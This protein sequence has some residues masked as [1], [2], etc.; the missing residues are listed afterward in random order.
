M[1]GKWRSGA[2]ATARR[3][4][5]KILEEEVFILCPAYREALLWINW[6]CQVRLRDV[7]ILDC[8]SGDRGAHSL[9]NFCEAHRLDCEGATWQVARVEEELRRELQ[10]RCADVLADTVNAGIS[11]SAAMQAAFQISTPAEL[12][13]SLPEYISCGTRVRVQ[14]SCARL[15]RL[16][17]LCNFT[18]EHHLLGLCR[19]EALKLLDLLRLPLEPGASH[20]APLQPPGETTST[21]TAS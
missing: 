1:F 9:E 11:A 20:C 21:Y 8:C 19:R 14:A 3:R 5:S 2:R 10:R 4:I 16:I 13:L 18:L 17:R 15:A 12:T 7:S 6:F